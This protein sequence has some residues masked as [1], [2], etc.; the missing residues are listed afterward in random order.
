MF[1][2][3]LRGITRNAERYPDPERFRPERFLDARGRLDLSI[4][5]PA[6]FVFGFGRR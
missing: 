3:N 4:R 2:F 5:D 1:Y 6:E